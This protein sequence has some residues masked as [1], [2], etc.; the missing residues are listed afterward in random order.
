M[1]GDASFHHITDC[2]STAT[3]ITT[4]PGI[5]G[6]VAVRPYATVTAASNA[7]LA[8]VRTLSLEH[9]EAT[10]TPVTNAWYATG[11]V[12]RQ[13]YGCAWLLDLTHEVSWDGKCEGQTPTYLKRRKDCFH[14]VAP[15]D[16]HAGI[17]WGNINFITICP[18][19]HMCLPP[20]S[21]A[22]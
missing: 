7:S 8:D 12:E 2:A 21:L 4:I 17:V 22:Q 6:G 18:E 11:R 15:V 19:G 13:R 14:Y 1:F 3:Q 9:G 16:A 5:T 10:L 20:R